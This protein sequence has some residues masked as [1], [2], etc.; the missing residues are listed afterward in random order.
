MPGE[1][2]RYYLQQRV[3]GEWHTL[4]IYSEVRRADHE[5]R[6]L[7]CQQSSELFR[8]VDVTGRRCVVHWPRA[9]LEPA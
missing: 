6:R 2:L 1:R 8:V 9:V 7:A 4:R 5:R 3:D